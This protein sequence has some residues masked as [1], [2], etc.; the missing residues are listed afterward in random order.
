MESKIQKESSEQI[1]EDIK[2][3]S[4]TSDTKPT[5]KVYIGENSCSICN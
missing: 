3:E 1:E 4:N 2:K 5:K